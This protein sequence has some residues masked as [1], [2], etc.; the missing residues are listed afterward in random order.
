M[1]LL[2]TLTKHCRLYNFIKMLSGA[3]LRPFLICIKILI[4]KSKLLNFKKSKNA[5][6]LKGN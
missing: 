1:T 3:I 6:I 5:D 2:M 4:E